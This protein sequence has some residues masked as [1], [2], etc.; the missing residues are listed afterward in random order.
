MMT[1]IYSKQTAYVDSL[2]VVLFFCAQAYAATDQWYYNQ[3]LT[4]PAD[5][6]AILEPYYQS[7]LQQQNFAKHRVLKQWAWLKQRSLSQV[8]LQL[9]YHVSQSTQGRALPFWPDLKPK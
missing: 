2:L 7:K 1:T 4:S 6:R 5:S 9:P 3:R 8:S